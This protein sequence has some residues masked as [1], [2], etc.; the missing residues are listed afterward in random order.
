M[1]AKSARD[2]AQ[3]NYER[4]LERIV[5]D[6]NRLE[7]EEAILR[8]YSF[9]SPFV[10]EVV[11]VSVSTGESITRGDVIARVVNSKTL[12]VEAYA[13]ATAFT[14]LKEGHSYRGRVESP[15]NLNFSAVLDHIDPVFEAATG[16]VRVVF[17]IDNSGGI[18][19]GAP[20]KIDLAPPA[21][22]SIKPATFEP[23]SQPADASTDW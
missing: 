16:A 19:V 5:L 13:P 11:E 4:T 6:A 1:D 17:T 7:L 3:F 10:G 22:M 15:F 2:E 21:I 18:P 9:Y 14:R 8:K 20:A 23:D 12:E